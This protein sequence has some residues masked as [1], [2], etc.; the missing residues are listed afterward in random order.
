MMQPDFQALVAE[1]VAAGVI[2]FRN[3]LAS[4]PYAPSVETSDGEDDEDADVPVDG[5]RGDPEERD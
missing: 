1:A 5:G 4:A 3:H 2:R